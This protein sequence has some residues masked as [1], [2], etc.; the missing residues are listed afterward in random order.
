[1]DIIPPYMFE[2]NI[3]DSE[4]YGPWMAETVGGQLAIDIAQEA[5]HLGM[6]VSPETLEYIYE[7]SLG[8]PGTTMKKMIN[9]TAN[10]FSGKPVR[11]NELPIL[12]RFLG[13]TYADGFEQLTGV[14]PDISHFEREQNTSS[15][16]NQRRHFKL[17]RELRKGRD[18]QERTSI[19][20][21]LIQ[22]ENKSV[23]RRLKKSMMDMRMGITKTD[24]DIRS[25]GVENGQRA[26]FFTEQIKKMP[27]GDVRAYILDQTRKKIMTP[28]VKIQMRLLG[29]FNYNR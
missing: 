17:L 28:E 5:S 15:V 2:M 29:A 3:P 6:E 22:G 25:L 20:Y 8:G 10:L 4:K 7:N 18:N 24:Q 19:Y 16:Q 1:M 27:P 14:A 9:A 12:R 26:A 21:S 13:R 23:Q 11:N